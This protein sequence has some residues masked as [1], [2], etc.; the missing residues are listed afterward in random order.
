MRIIYKKQLLSMVNRAVIDV[1]SDVVQ[2][3]NLSCLV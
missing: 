1:V 2:S 3:K